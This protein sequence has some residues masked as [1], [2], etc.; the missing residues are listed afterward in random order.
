MNKEEYKEMV[1]QITP[2]EK[3]W[4]NA[5]IAFLVGGLMG[6]LSVLIVELIM[7]F[8]LSEKD[9]TIWML[10]IFI[11]LAVLFTNLGFFDTWVSKVKAGLIV[12]IT[13]F[14]HSVAASTLDYR[15]DGFVTG[16]G[17]N[18][19]KLAGSVLLYGTFAAFS[20][21]LLKVILNG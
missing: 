1:K 7:I 9:S 6:V 14:A 8:G 10:I 17:A 3:K 12:P 5:S 13:G 11:F 2:K 16:I 18:I 20:L 15:K 21:V 19:F 4:K